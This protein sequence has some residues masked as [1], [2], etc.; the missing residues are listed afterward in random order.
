MK[1]F[2]STT[3]FKKEVKGN[4]YIL[5]ITPIGGYTVLKN[6]VVIG[7]Y[8]EYAKAFKAFQE[9]IYIG[10]GNNPYLNEKRK[11]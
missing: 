4:E 1:K 5:K 3:L 2:T 9:S 8:S 10:N 6:C 11:K 7:T